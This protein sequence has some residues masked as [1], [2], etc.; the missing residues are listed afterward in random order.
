MKEERK[1]EKRRIIKKRWR[2][3]EKERERGESGER[4]MAERPSL[5]S[6]EWNGWGWTRRL[7]L[8]AIKSGTDVR[9]MIHGAGRASPRQQACGEYSGGV[10][11]SVP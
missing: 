2:E 11:V 3:K 1:G 4:V 7:C 10:C 6:D 9:R 8:S 5:E